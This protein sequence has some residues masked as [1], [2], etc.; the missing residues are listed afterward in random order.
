[1]PHCPHPLLLSLNNIAPFPFVSLTANQPPGLSLAQKTTNPLRLSLAQQAP[2]PQRSSLSHSIAPLQHA[3]LPFF[4]LSQNPPPP[5]LGTNRKDLPQLCPIVVVM[6]LCCNGLCRSR[7]SHQAATH[8]S[9]F[10]FCFL[11]L[12]LDLSDLLWMGCKFSI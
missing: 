11:F 10:C 8:P 1:V 7:E 2:L 6:E 3:P 9:N 4:D 5:P 12:F